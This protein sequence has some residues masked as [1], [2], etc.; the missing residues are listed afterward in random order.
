VLVLMFPHRRVW[1]RLVVR[2]DGRGM[3]SLAG[4]GRRDV[5]S[6]T[7]FTDLVTDVRAAFTTPTD[8]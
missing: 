4:A 3:L 1:G 2:S 8:A 7:E 5:N 6:N